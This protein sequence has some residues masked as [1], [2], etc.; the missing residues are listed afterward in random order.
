MRVISF[1]QSLPFFLLDFD[2]WHNLLEN[3]PSDKGRTKKIFFWKE[4]QK[5]PKQLAMKYASLNYD[6]IKALMHVFLKAFCKMK[7]FIQ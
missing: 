5:P 4:V 1:L 3:K 2:L 6:G 7:T